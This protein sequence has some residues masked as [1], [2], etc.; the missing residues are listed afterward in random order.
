MTSRDHG[1]RRLAAARRGTGAQ[2]DAAD[3][4]RPEQLPDRRPA[5]ALVAVHLRLRRDARSA[6]R[7]G[8]GGDR[9][10]DARGRQPAG[11]VSQ[12][13]LFHT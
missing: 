2:G 8:R 4:P 11:V 1:T 13:A 9:A 3:P 6:A 10:V 12:F 7:A 5:A